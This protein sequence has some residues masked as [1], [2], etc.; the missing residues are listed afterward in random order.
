MLA[1]AL[2]F[3]AGVHHLLDHLVVVIL[4]ERKS[5]CDDA[6]ACDRLTFLGLAQRN[7]VV[8]AG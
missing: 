1:A 5:K 4:G 2:E 7:R 3:A 8:G 6:A